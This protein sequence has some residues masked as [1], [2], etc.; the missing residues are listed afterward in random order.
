MEAYIKEDELLNKIKENIY[1]LHPIRK[2]RIDSLAYYKK[3]E[4]KPEMSI[5][6]YFFKDCDNLVKVQVCFMDGC[7]GFRHG[8]N[9]SY[10]ID[11]S[12]S[13]ETIGKLISF[14]LINFPYMRSLH[15]TGTGFEMNFCIGVE[16]EEEEG[17][18]CS[19]IDIVFK[20]NYL[21][22]DDF[23]ELFRKY[24]EYITDN[25][26]AYVSKTPE[27]KDAYNKWAQKIM[28]ETI[29]SLSHDE[30][31]NFIDLID[32]DVMRQLL[33]SMNSD[34]FFEICESFQKNSETTK[35]KL[36]E[37]KLNTVDTSIN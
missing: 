27:F 36:L 29:M 2:P 15:T 18:G 20:T 33:F 5:D 13:E 17:I 8:V 14:I 16:H 31:N 10:L 21:L 24:I 11:T 34:Y 9:N 25:F 22:Y 30:L 4:Q 32:D 23:K 3:C 12:I 7:R 6:F 19:S 1:T 26:Y 35:K 37:L 28:T